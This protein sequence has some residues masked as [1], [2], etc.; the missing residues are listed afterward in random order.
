MKVNDANS[1]KNNL[2]VE[3]SFDVYKR[4]LKSFGRAFVRVC[5]LAHTL[6]AYTGFTLKKPIRHK[7]TKQVKL[8]L[9]DL[10]IKGLPQVLFKL[11]M[12]KVINLHIVL[13][14]LSGKG[15]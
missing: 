13:R 12:L 6:Y 5:M 14:Y 3:L 11:L 2:Q 8:V 4:K 7:F 9:T 1:S 10:T 15:K